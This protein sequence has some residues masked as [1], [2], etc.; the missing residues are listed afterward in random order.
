MKTS[1][2]FRAFTSR[3]KALCTFVPCTGP[4]P[5]PTALCALYAAAL[6]SYFRS[7]LARER[8]NAAQRN[9]EILRERRG[10]LV[11]TLKA[12]DEAYRRLEYLNYDLA[13][14][15]EV[16]EEASLL[17]V[18]YA[19]GFGQLQVRDFLGDVL[20]V[21]QVPQGLADDAHRLLHL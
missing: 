10:Q 19:H 11:R 1:L 12:L 5:G 17:P 13:R 21:G 15:R 6:S 3:W 20:A 9:E 18:A 16:A 2:L 7:G 4:R 8:A 14:A